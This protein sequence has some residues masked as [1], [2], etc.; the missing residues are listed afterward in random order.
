MKF[1]IKN[2]LPVAAVDFFFHGSHVHLKNV[3][4]VISHLTSV[5]GAQVEISLE[6]NVKSPEGLSSQTVRTV[7]ENCQ[8]LKVRSFGFDE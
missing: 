6:V 5:D 8:T 4:E 3:E 7:S 2:G 1:I